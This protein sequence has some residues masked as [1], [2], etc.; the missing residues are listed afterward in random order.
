MLAI[1]DAQAQDSTRVPD[2]TRVAPVVGDTTIANPAGTTD[3]QPRLIGGLRALQKA[4][5][6]PRKARKQGIE[7]R[8]VVR[9]IVDERGRVTEAE[10]AEPVHPLLDDAALTAVRKMRFEPAQKDGEPVSVQLSVPIGFWQ[11]D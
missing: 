8:V 4:T 6:Y 5:K 10:V 2:T 11:N 7:G 1:T 3:R 9:F